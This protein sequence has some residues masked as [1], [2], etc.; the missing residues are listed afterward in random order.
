MSS[1]TSFIFRQGK[2]IVAIGRNYAEHAKELNNKVPKEPFFFLKPT[3]SYVFNGGNVEIPDG[4]VA[5][6][7]VELGVVIGKTGRDVSQ[8][9]AE[10]LIAGYALAVDMTARNLQDQVKKRG[11]PWSAAK[12]FDT[13]TPIGEFIAKSAIQDPHNLNLALKING[14]VKQDGNTSDMIFQIPQLIEHITSIMTLAPGD[15]ILTGTPSGVGPV[16]A[17]DKIECTMS[18]PASGKILSTLN[19]LAINRKGG[20]KFTPE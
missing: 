18:D 3:S 19:L 7:E 10:S 13:F 9:D 14:V 6:H 15:V 16:A 20:Y 1:L 2:Q 5:H 17:G 4:I 11:L 8:A 12:G